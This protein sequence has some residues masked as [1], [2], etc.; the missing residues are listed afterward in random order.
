MKNRARIK[1]RFNIIT[2]KGLGKTYDL[3][4]PANQDNYFEIT[5]TH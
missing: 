5:K 2:G 4:E 3:N 1:I